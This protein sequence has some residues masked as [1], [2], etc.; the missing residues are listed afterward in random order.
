MS[1]AKQSRP[2]T[3]QWLMPDYESY[4]LVGIPTQ[5]HPAHLGT[6]RHKLSLQ[7][8]L[9]KPNS[10]SWILKSENQ[11]RFVLANRH[12]GPD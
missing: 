4:F 12:G 2:Q 1:P 7:G 10:R 6:S 3:V 8:C 5:V 9:D 11:C